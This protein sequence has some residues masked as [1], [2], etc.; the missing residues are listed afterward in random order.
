MQNFLNL[1]LKTKLENINPIHEEAEEY[2][3][4]PY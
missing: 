2:S 3:E 1:S 4:H